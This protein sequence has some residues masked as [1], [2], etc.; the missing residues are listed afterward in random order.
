MSDEESTDWPDGEERW[1]AIVEF[2]TAGEPDVNKGILWAAD[3]IARL[4]AENNRLAKAWE[5]KHDQSV[6]R[7]KDYYELH[8]EAN[9]LVDA[10]RDENT[11]LEARLER[12]EGALKNE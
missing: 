2:A 3:E 12:L 11:T 9:D 1:N 7:D 4:E 5:K 8:K 6:E 10:L